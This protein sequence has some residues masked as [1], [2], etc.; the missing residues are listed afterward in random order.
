MYISRMRASYSSSHTPYTLPMLYLSIHSSAHWTRGRLGHRLGLGGLAAS[1][2]LLAHGSIYWAVR[3]VSIE[4][5]LPDG[6]PK[7][8][9]Q[10][11]ADA[12]KTCYV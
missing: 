11:G 8:D 6:L 4:R 3:G 7:A 2:F 12:A 1:A 5:V 10:I 9:Y